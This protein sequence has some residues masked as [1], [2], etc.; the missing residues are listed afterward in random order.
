[1]AYI[2]WNHNDF[3]EWLDSYYYFS[4]DIYSTYPWKS[5]RWNRTDSIKLGVGVIQTSFPNFN[6]NVFENNVRVST[7]NFFNDTGWAD[8]IQTMLETNPGIELLNDGLFQNDKKNNSIVTLLD[9]VEEMLQP[10]GD[11]PWAINEGKFNPDRLCMRR[12]YINVLPLALPFQQPINSDIWI[13]AYNVIPPRN[14]VSIGQFITA[15]SR[16]ISNTFRYPPM[17]LLFVRKDARFVQPIRPGS[18]WP[19]IKSKPTYY[20]QLTGTIFQEQIT[21]LTTTMTSTLIATLKFSCLGGFLFNGAGVSVS[22]YSFSTYPNSF[23]WAVN[24]QLVRY[25]P[26]SPNNE[27]EF[28]QTQ[29]T[30]RYL[31]TGNGITVTNNAWSPQTW[32]INPNYNVTLFYPFWNNPDTVKANPFYPPNKPIVINT[33]PLYIPFGLT[34]ML[35]GC[36]GLYVS[37]DLLWNWSSFEPFPDNITPTMKNMSLNEIIC[38]ISEYS[39]YYNLTNSGKDCQS[40]TS[41]FCNPNLP[42]Y[43][44][45]SCTCYNPQKMIDDNALGE[46]PNDFLQI[47]SANIVCV[48]A[49]C[50]DNPYAFKS[51]FQVPLSEF[52]ECPKS[53]QFCQIS[54][55]TQIGKNPTLVNNCTQNGNIPPNP[56]ISITVIVICFV[57]AILFFIGGIAILLLRKRKRRKSDRKADYAKSQYDYADDDSDLPEEYTHAF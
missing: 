16:G 14:Y 45:S 52:G 34:Q 1:M 28:F 37:E 27:T 56:Y 7:S 10:N 39:Y 36:I 29:K 47:I 33:T 31:S 23:P 17:N 9:Y 30:Y 35:N 5:M 41:A 6:P 43:K 2:T 46:N 21:Q 15:Y 22:T 48:Y 51:I 38:L 8:L 44:F 18:E 49:L 11:K 26:N 57:I 19:G 12:D 55:N 53:L 54:G 3:K 50:K 40:I 4:Q 32:V 25:F 42:Y 13:C 24:T 20:N